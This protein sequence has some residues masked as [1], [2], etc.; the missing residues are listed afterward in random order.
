MAAHT[1]LDRYNNAAKTLTNACRSSTAAPSGAA[2]PSTTRRRRTAAEGVAADPVRL[3]PRHRLHARGRRELLAGLPGRR[4]RDLL[5]EVV[6]PTPRRSCRHRLR[7]GRRH[8]VAFAP[9]RCRSA[10]PVRADELGSRRAVHRA[11]VRRAGPRARGELHALAG[12]GRRR[13]YRDGSIGAVL[14]HR[15]RPPAHQRRR[16]GDCHRLHLDDGRH[17]TI[18]IAFAGVALA[19]GAWYL[20]VSPQAF[21]KPAAANPVGAT[22]TLIGAQTRAAGDHAVGQDDRHRRSPSPPTPRS[23]RPATSA[24]TIYADS[25]DANITAFTDTTHVTATSAPTS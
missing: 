3:Q 23:S 22:V 2:A 7:A 9:A 24:T 15:R 21:A 14:A 8:D 4:R 20:D 18:T 10:A 19:S 11:A 1:D 12:H 17:I 13:P 25:G 6:T 5:A 16:R